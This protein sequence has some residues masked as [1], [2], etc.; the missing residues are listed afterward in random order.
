MNTKYKLKK[1]IVIPAGTIFGNAPIR[2][3]RYPTKEHP[4]IDCVFSLNNK[5]SSGTL[6]YYPE[7]YEWFE[8]VK[9]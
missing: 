6:T 7:V 2:T 8:T 3:V 9:K 1:D 4:I 5:D